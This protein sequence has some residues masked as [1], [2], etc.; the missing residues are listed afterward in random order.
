MEL[1]QLLDKFIQH[2]YDGD[3]NYNIAWYYESIGQTS[4]AISFYLRAAEKYSVKENIYE[5]LIR[6]GI[7]FDKQGKR[8]FSSKGLYQHAV[9]VLPKRPEAYYHLSRFYE[10]ENRS[11]HWQDCYMISSIAQEFCNLYVEPLRT[12]VGFPGDYG[13]LFQKAVSSWWCGLVDE[14]KRLFV[15][16]WNNYELDENHKASVLNNINTLKI[17][18]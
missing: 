7:C 4:S 17:Q 6:A 13:L 18:L 11:G 9:T 12:D 2:P 15:D 3:N 5:S 16:L 14:S 8:T 10:I 1:I